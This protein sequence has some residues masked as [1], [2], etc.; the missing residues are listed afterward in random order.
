[1]IEDKTR[2]TENDLLNMVSSQF[3]LRFQAAGI[4]WKRSRA[5]FLILV[6]SP[7]GEEPNTCP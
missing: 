4:G 6:L 7:P 3:P 1:M 5:D 2:N